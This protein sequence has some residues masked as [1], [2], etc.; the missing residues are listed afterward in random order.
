MFEDVSVALNNYESASVELL[1]DN[2]RRD[3][4]TYMAVTLLDR[5]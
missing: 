3:A 4:P 5:I 1:T 2:A